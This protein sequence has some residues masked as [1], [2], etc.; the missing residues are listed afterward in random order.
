MIVG[1]LSETRILAVPFCTNF[2][3]KYLISDGPIQKKII[4][5]KVVRR[6][7]VKS[8]Q[9][10]HPWRINKVYQAKITFIVSEW[11]GTQ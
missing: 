6:R 8:Q 10:I 7:K 3:Y 1:V 4:A 2:T 9:W 11:N 5:L